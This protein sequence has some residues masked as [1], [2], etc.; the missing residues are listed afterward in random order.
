MID[1]WI[2]SWLAVLVDGSIRWGIVL[3]MLAVW[4]ALRP[5]RRAATRHLLCVSALAAGAVLPFTPR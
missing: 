2:S 5:P 3:S 1:R 4:F